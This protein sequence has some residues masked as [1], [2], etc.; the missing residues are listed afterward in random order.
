[1]VQQTGKIVIW[2][3]KE[4]DRIFESAEIEAMF[5]G[6]QPLKWEMLEILGYLD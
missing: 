6:L 2:Y 1:M 3:H 5:C 4:L